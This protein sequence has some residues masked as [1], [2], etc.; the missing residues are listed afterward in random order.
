[1]SVFRPVTI[2]SEFRDSLDELMAVLQHSSPHFVRCIR[3]NAD[4]RPRLLIDDQVALQ[5]Q[6]CGVMETIKIRAQV[7]QLQ[8]MFFYYYYY[9][10]YYY[11]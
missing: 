6:Y 10:Y 4:K 2:G 7:R 3:P 5:L 8:H 1:M 9:Y 11:V